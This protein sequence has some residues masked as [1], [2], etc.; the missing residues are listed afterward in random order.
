MHS[1]GRI[2]VA[3]VEL[4]KPYVRC[5]FCGTYNYIPIKY[6]KREEDYDDEYDYDDFEDWD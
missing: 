2:S 3:N 6:G 5:E 4:G 1:S